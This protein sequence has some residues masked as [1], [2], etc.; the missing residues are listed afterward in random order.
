MDEP[1]EPEVDEQARGRSRRPATWQVQ[2]I[3]LVLALGIGAFVLTRASAHGGS[4]SSSQSVGPG[5]GRTAP[6][7]SLTLLNGRTVNLTA[8]HGQSLMVWFVANGCASCAV[9]IPAVAQHLGAF[10]RSK[11][12]IVVV[13]LYGTF[14]SGHAGTANLAGFGKAAAGPAFSSRTWTWGLSSEKLTEAYDPG[15][16]PDA[17]FLVSPTGRLVYENS[18]PVSTMPA[19][20]A[21]LEHT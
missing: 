19:L 5:V 6:N 9:S 4:A 21:H 17:Y 18:V 3:V 12:R 16:V 8:F 13:G 2:L 11:T 7:G 14:G 15:G 10:A 1:A 20:I